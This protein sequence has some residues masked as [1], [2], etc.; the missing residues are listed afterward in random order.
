MLK[1]VVAEGAENN[2]EAGVINDYAT[3]VQVG[4]H[5]DGGG[6]DAT[7]GEGRETNKPRQQDLS[8]Y[9]GQHAEDLHHSPDLFVVPW[10]DQTL[11]NM[12]N[13]S[14]Q[15]SVQLDRLSS[16]ELAKDEEHVSHAVVV[17]ELHLGEPHT[18]E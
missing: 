4:R 6:D 12:F 9:F 16:T 5:N 13:R 18:P 17:H 14:D 10:P 11:L 3:A 2:V 15:R 1:T 8:I 7:V